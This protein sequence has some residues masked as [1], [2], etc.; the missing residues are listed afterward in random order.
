MIP[1]ADV[2]CHLLAGLDD[3]PK[4]QEEAVAMCRLAYEDGTRTIAATAHLFHYWKAVTPER[5]RAATLLLRKALEENGIYLSIVPSAE[6][7]IHLE[8]ESNWRENRLLS[9]GDG[10]Q[11]LLVE[12][13]ENQFF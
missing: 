12:M 7:M 13:P 1:L 6:I 8:I 11:T 4:T 5:I 10:R 9:V 2:H 3:G